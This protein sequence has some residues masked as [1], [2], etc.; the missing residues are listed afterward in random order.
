MVALSGAIGRTLADAR[1][2]MEGGLLDRA[3]QVLA[4]RHDFGKVLLDIEDR[5]AGMEPAESRRS[6]EAKITSLQSVVEELRS[7]GVSVTQIRPQTLWEIVDGCRRHNQLQI[8]HERPTDG[9]FH[10]RLVDRASLCVTTLLDCIFGNVNDH[11]SA[12]G[13]D[14]AGNR[15]PRMTFTTCRVQG[16]TQAVVQIENKS[17]DFLDQRFCAELYRYPV[18]G[19]HGEIRLGTY[20]AT[21]NAR[22]I[23]GRIHAAVLKDGQTVRTTIVVPVGDLRADH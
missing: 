7:T 11:S 20:I 6:V 15:V 9:I 10:E 3:A 5:L 12:D 14:R 1:A 16:D 8:L 2:E 23:G 21:I 18:K 17:L 22:R 19:T 4:K 13:Y